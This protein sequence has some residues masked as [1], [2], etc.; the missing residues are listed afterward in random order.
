MIEWPDEFDSWWSGLEARSASDPDAAAVLDLL[1]AELGVLQDLT[2]PPVEDTKTLMRVRQSRRYPV[3]RVSHPYDPNHAVRTIA[4]FP[5]SE[6]VV[7][8]LFAND[9]AAMGDV[10]YDSVGSRA[11]QI[12]DKWLR[13]RGTP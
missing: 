13:E 11:D 10:F 7:V 8:A 2:G 6:H 9:K 12:I 1:I 4:W 3:W 5:D